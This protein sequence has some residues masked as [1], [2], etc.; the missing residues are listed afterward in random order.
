[1]NSRILPLM[2][3]I[4]LIILL[5]VG[6]K[7]ADHKTELPSPLIGKS[8]PGSPTSVPVFCLALTVAVEPIDQEL[9]R[10]LRV[11]DRLETR[12]LAVSIP[13]SSGPAGPFR[14]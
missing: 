10:L 13:T 9:E 3:F 5:V 8:A 4:L 6:L 14:A 2:A 1:M 12:R 7:I 11:T